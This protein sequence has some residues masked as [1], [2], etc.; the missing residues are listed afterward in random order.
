MKDYACDLW[1]RASRALQTAQHD[2]DVEDYDAAASRA[3][4]AAFHGVSAVFA[5]E[6]KTFK[7]HSAVEAM[8]HKELVKS[9]RLPAQLG[10]DYQSIRVLRDTGDYGGL[11]HVTAE[12]AQE[13]IQAAQRILE[14]IKELCP[15]LDEGQTDI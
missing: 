14:A 4:Y 1:Q 9:G 8:F 12:Q 11:E 3:Y 6:G 5:L 15:E 7:K 13:A 10:S 2:A